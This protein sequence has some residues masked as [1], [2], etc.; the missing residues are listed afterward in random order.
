MAKYEVYE[1]VNE[2]TRKDGNYFGLT[3]LKRGPQYG[4]CSIC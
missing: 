4:Y 3:Y 1:V 2:E